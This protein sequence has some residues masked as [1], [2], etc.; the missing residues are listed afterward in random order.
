MFEKLA[1]PYE[2]FGKLRIVHNIL[3]HLKRYDIIKIY[4]YLLIRKSMPESIFNLTIFKGIDHDTIEKIVVNCSEKTFTEGEMIIIE[5]E[6]SNGEGYI[7]KSWK[8]SIGIRWQKI[9]ELHS[10]DIFW[11]IALLNEEERTATVTALE[12]IEVIVLSLED[13]IEM[14]N[15][16]ENQINKTIMERIEA[17]LDS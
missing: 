2:I 10:G 1:N 14:I 16:D 4:S 13:L 15:N 9:A 5:W 6:N 8:V 7:L 11:E 12:D 17:N 3:H